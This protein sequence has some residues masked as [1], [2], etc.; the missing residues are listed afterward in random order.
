MVG[1]DLGGRGG[2]GGFG[3][4]L[5]P[6]RVDLCVVKVVVVSV[7][8]AS[9]TFSAKTIHLLQTRIILKIKGHVPLLTLFTSLK[10]INC[11]VLLTG[12]VPFGRSPGVVLPL[13][14]VWL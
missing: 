2:V 5:G 4:V 1:V 13:F 10:K 9:H 14:K 3:V 12:G 6:G 11:Y 7:W 8:L